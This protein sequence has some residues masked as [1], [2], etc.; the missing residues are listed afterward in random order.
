MRQNERFYSFEPEIGDGD[1]SFFSELIDSGVNHNDWSRAELFAKLF[2]N[3]SVTAAFY[4]SDSKLVDGIPVSD[5]LRDSELSYEEKTELMKKC[6][7]NIFVNT[8]DIMLRELRGRYLWFTLLLRGNGS[9]T[10]SVSAVKIMRD[11]FD[12]TSFLPEIYGGEANDFTRRF[13]SVFQRL[14]ERMNEKIQDL[15]LIFDIRKNDG[16]MPAVMARWIG[17]D[18]VS[19]FDGERLRRLVMR[20][21]EL[22]SRIG[23]AG[24]LEDIVELYTGVRPI[25]LDGCDAADE[26]QANAAWKTGGYP[27]S[28][29]SF[30]VL[31]P[32]K[33]VSTE[34]DHKTVLK[35]I[36]EYKPA[37]M[38]FKLIFT[39]F[40]WNISKSYENGVYLNDRMALMK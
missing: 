35:L 24:M 7:S 33:A 32:N 36:T 40:P 12:W 14:Y 29:F 28:A 23:T 13:L 20:A 34:E 25:I 22:Q 17:L 39:D 26:T 5:I 16:D 4:A 27:R 8:R 11:R 37:H 19:G 15:P 1:D 9:D 6:A 31:L 2:P 10:P 18:C 21:S 3:T 30:A 38:S